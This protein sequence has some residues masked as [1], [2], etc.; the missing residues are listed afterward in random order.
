MKLVWGCLGGWGSLGFGGG[1]VCVCAF[2][3]RQLFS[4]LWWDYVLG[5]VRGGAL[6]KRIMGLSVALVLE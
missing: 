5:P 4:V 3:R 6:E 2:P 1:V